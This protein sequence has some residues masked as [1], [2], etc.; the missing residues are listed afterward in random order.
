MDIRTQTG[1][2]SAL[3]SAHVG[4]GGGQIVIAREEQRYVDRYTR[5]DRLLDGRRAFFGSW[6]FD[7][8][9]AP[10]SFFVKCLGLGDCCGSIV[11]EEWR[12]FQGYPAVNASGAFMDRSEQIGSS[13]QV[14]QRQLKKQCF[15]GTAAPQESLNL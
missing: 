13:P 12:D 7:E 8:Q 9:V 1:V 5:K 11:G 10:L 4:L 2:D 15:A 6:N 3:Q 14:L